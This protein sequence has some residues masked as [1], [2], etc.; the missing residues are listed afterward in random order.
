MAAK[1]LQEALDYVE[2]A[3]SMFLESIKETD[4]ESAAILFQLGHSFLQVADGFES[5]VDAEL[6]K[7]GARELL[8]RLDAAT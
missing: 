5:K 7:A 4:Q 6:R 2:R 8:R 3:T 1:D